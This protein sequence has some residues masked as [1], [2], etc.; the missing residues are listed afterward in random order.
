LLPCCAEDKSLSIEYDLR[1]IK[2]ALEWVTR[3][4][5]LLLLVATLVGR[6]RSVR[7][8]I[9]DEADSKD[10]EVLSIR[11]CWLPFCTGPFSW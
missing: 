3:P 11:W 10:T 9:L 1:S 6:Y 5:V 4:S 8:R 2:R 7:R